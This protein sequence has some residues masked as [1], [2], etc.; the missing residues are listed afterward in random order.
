MQPSQSSGH[1]RIQKNDL[2]TLSVFNLFP[3]PF[4]IYFLVTPNPIPQIPLGFPSG[5][6]YVWYI[7][8]TIKDFLLKNFFRLLRILGILAIIYASMVFYL[9][10]SERHIAYPRA[11]ENKA[12]RA[13]L[14]GGSERSCA[15]GDG[16]ALQGWVLNDSAAAFLAEVSSIK[17]V[18]LITFNYRG[19]AG[20]PGTPEAK[21]AAKDAHGIAE[22]AL[23]S[24]RGGA[25][26]ISGRGIG[27]A[28]ALNENNT[29]HASQAILIDPAKSTAAEIHRKYGVFFPEFIAGKGV[30]IRE[31]IS[32]PSRGIV[33][34]EDHRERSSLTAEVLRSLGNKAV[35]KE[36]GGGT[37]ADALS[38]FFDP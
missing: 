36:R 22:C 31:P 20:N 2:R 27:A 18:R 25:V 13:M 5:I 38:V 33:I 35:Y 19:S 8:Q 24:A 3:P 17:N 16:I 21:Y 4:F 9:K 34:L 14:P 29:V 10:L 12:A 11:I 37:L 6:F 7:M 30:F 23:A 28:H 15:L 26:V 32:S 1:G